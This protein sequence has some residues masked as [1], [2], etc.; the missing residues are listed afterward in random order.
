VAYHKRVVDLAQSN[1]A[2]TSVLHPFFLALILTHLDRPVTEYAKSSLEVAEYHMNVAQGDLLLA[3]GLLEQIST[4]N[5]EDVA[6]ATELLKAVKAR[7]QQKGLGF[8]GDGVGPD[9]A[10]DVSMNE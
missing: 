3:K 10:A 9:N 1:S 8:V 6:K 4:S 7:L 2:L 5:A